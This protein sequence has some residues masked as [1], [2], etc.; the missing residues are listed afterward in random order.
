MPTP[1]LDS[2]GELEPQLSEESHGSLTGGRVVAHAGPLLDLGQGGL[3]RQSGPVGPMTDHRLD[4]VGDRQNAR[5]GQDVTILQ[6]VGVAGTVEAL[7]MLADHLGNV[8]LELDVGED[9]GAG[10]GMLADEQHLGLAQ[11]ARLAQDL[12]RHDDFADVVEQRRR[13]QRPDLLFAPA[14]LGG[15]R[16][17]QRADPTLMTGGV[18][19]AQFRRGA[20]CGDGRP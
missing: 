4:D 1:T 5:L 12:R 11:P 7:V 9:L 13:A 20:Q 3:Q 8:A 2:F 19:V 10:A 15:D 18:G 6:A 16:A 14:E 17:G